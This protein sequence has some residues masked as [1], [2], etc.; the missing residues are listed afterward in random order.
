[1]QPKKEVNID[2]LGIQLHRGPKHPKYS[3]P[4]SRLLTYTDWPRRLTRQTPETL[5]QAGFYYID[6]RDNQNWG[7]EKMGLSDQVRCFHCDGGLSS[8]DPTDDPFVEH[9]RWFP[10]CGYITLVRGTQFVKDMLV[11][12]PPVLVLTHCGFMLPGSP[13]APGKLPQLIMQAP[14]AIRHLTNAPLNIGL[15]RTETNEANQNHVDIIGESSQSL[16][17]LVDTVLDIQSNSSQD[18][19]KVESRGMSQSMPTL[20]EKHSLST[21]QD[22]DEYHSISAVSTRSLELLPAQISYSSRVHKVSTR[23]VTLLPDGMSTNNPPVLLP[24]T[25]TTCAS[26]NGLALDALPEKHH[27]EVTMYRFSWGVLFSAEAPLPIA[28]GV[29]S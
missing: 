16:A 9:A 13:L 11:K 10:H 29:I 1:S 17:E 19:S 4:E 18:T 8:W 20:H 2:D 25:S 24:E 27:E 23:S 26:K 12:H 14:P 21:S 5:V 6:R 22:E 15:N 28:W 7:R 3:T